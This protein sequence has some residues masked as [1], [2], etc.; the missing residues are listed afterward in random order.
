MSLGEILQRELRGI[1]ELSAAQISALER[2]YELLLHWNRRMN[3]TTVTRLPEA[4]L[5]HYS[6]SLF[7]AARLSRG[8]AVDVGSGAGFPGIPVAITRPDCRVTLVESHQRK[9]VFLREASRGL[10][11][12]RVVAARAETLQPGYEWLVSRAVDPSELMKLRIARRFAILLGAGDAS[13]LAA[14]DVIPLPW[15]ERRVL[16]IGTFHVKQDHRNS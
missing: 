4:A 3:L 7:L 6:E 1:V 13:R 15:G 2:H 14:D 9:A 5:R 12:V 16:A 8:E 11:E 10:E